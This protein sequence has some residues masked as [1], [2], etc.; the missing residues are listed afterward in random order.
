MDEQNYN[1]QYE[2]N[3]NYQYDMNNQQY[4]YQAGG[5]P[6]PPK[7]SNVLAIVGMILGIISIPAG[8]CGWYSLLLGIPG[9][10]CSILSRK[11]GKSGM[12]VAGIVCSIIGIIIGVLMTVMAY[13]VVAI[14]ATEPEFQQIFEMYGL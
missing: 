11:Q 3:N 1:N 5:Q 6:Q 12:S 7:Q 2:Q 8:C 9:L 10:V 4:S 14:L 13:L